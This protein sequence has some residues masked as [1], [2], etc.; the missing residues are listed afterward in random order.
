ML[1]AFLRDF[2]DIPT[3]VTLLSWGRAVADTALGRAGKFAD[4]ARKPLLGVAGADL[5]KVGEGIF[6]VLFLVLLIGKA[7]RAIFGGP[8]D[9]LAGRGSVVVIASSGCNGRL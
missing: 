7:G 2:E 3:A 5:A 8:M 4:G 6:P 9:G 1:T